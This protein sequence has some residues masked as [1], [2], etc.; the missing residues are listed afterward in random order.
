MNYCEL[1]LKAN[2]SLK[3]SFLI[4]IFKTANSILSVRIMLFSAGWIIKCAFSLHTTD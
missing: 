4:V 1:K 2:L 3:Q